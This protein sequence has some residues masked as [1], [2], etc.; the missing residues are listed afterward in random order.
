MSKTGYSLTYRKELDAEQLLAIYGDFSLEESARI[1]MD[2]PRQIKEFVEKDIRCPSC[3]VAGALLV[4]AGKSKVDARVVKQAHFRFV[5]NGHDAHLVFCEHSP[6]YSEQ[7]SLGGGVSLSSTRSNLTR[8]V[9]E[10]TCKGIERGVFSQSDIS[11]MRKWYYDTKSS[12]VY[13]ITSTA[14]AMRFVASLHLDG[15]KTSLG[16]HPAHCDSPNYDWEWEARV[17]IATAHRD[18]FESIHQA[19]MLGD[20]SSVVKLLE[21][22]KRRVAYDLSLLQPY[23]DSCIKLS[24]FLGRQIWGSKRYPQTVPAEFLALCSLLLYV[25]GWN[26]DEAGLKLVEL[27]KA[28]KPSDQLLGNIMG[29]NPFHDYQTWRTVK[30]LCDL[31]LRYDLEVDYQLLVENTIDGMREEYRRWKEETGATLSAE[32]KTPMPPMP[33]SVW[34]DI[35]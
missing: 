9:R 12:A 28:P 11:G 25:S 18:L 22:G 17:R 7:T 4:S 19:R 1:L 35:F 26:L 21:G 3:G 6:A 20:K 29:L 30:A 23:Y 24:E 13:D 10:L 2:A 5:N 15:W 32:K 27:L 33:P 31:G 34:D 14:Q 16:F 8:M